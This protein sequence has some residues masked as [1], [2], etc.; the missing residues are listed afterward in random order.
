MEKSFII[1]LIFAIIV[2]IFAINNAGKVLIDFIFTE[3]YVS[4]AL[5]ILISSILGA[6]IVAILSGVKNIKLKKDK[7]KTQDELEE[8]KLEKSNLE[9]LLEDKIR[10]ISQLKK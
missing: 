10:E 3:V 1:A 6:G 4:Q 7:E 9:A 5:V 2:A 8:L